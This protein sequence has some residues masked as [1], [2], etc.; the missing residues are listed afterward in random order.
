MGLAIAAAALSRKHIVRL[1]VG[2]IQVAPPA[3]LDRLIRVET[4][5]EMCQAVVENVGWCEALVMAA[6]VA[7]WRPRQ[8]SF[9]KLK[10]HAGPVMLELQPTPDILATVRTMKGR[11]IFVGFA[12]ETGDPVA[13]A[14]RKLVEKGLDLIVANDVTRSGAGFE[15]DTNQV[16]LISASG[17]MRELPLM[18]KTE[19]A[20]HIM[21]WIEEAAQQT[22][23][24]ENVSG[25][26][27]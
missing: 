17:V 10:K 3:G 2:P 27:D 8:T 19:V 4:S 11:K 13:E 16:V 7:D 5:Q 15:V 26:A 12:A 18:P 14:R 1:I 23:L 22:V 6:A 9:A 25:G 20:E 21:A 24:P